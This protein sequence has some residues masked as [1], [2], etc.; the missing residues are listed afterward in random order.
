MPR[1]ALAIKT[2]FG[3]IRVSG[4]TPGEVLEALQALDQEFISEVNERVSDLLATQA[5]DDLKG[6]VEMA[7]D[8]PIIVTKKKLSH[9]EAIG[10]ILYSMRDHQSSS[11]EITKRLTA[12]GKKVTVPA[13]LHE[14][15]KRGH[16]FK[17]VDRAPYYKLSTRGVKWIE[18]EVLP[19]LKKK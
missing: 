18:E 17:P 4:D 16:I 1:V 5:K 3:E 12:S 6:V 9:Y 13:R 15:R 19:P 2:P 11:R 10:L 7:R 8:G 14:M